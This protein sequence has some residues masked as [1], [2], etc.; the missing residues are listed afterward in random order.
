MWIQER[1]PW[2]YWSTE[3]WMFSRQ[4]WNVAESYCVEEINNDSDW[5]QRCLSSV[6]FASKI[7]NLFY[8]HC[9]VKW[10]RAVIDSPV[11]SKAHRGR[12]NQIQVIVCLEYDN[13]YTRA[14]ISSKGQST[15]DSFN[16]FHSIL[17]NI[18]HNHLL[19]GETV[20]LCL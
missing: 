3:C 7:L 11:V 18:D 19:L 5:D 9:Y 6:S 2:H 16:D 4:E 14:V 12:W 17:Q 10:G 8:S 13:L 20:D 15:V 1:P